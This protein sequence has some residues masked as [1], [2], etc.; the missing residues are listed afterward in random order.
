MDSKEPPIPEHDSSKEA[1]RP[2]VSK[3]HPLFGCMKGMIRIAPG[4]DLTEPANPEWADRLD[5]MYK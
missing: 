4:V 1:N 5:E 3:R 2:V